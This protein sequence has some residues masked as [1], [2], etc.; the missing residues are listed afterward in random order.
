M[1]LNLTDVL[2]YCFVFLTFYLATMMFVEQFESPSWNGNQYNDFDFFENICP[3][4]IQTMNLCEF[5]Q[6]TKLR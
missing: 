5:M 4:Q 2:T 3:K 1:W 6:L